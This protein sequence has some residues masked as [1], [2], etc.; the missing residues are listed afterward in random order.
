MNIRKQLDDL[1]GKPSL[2]NLAKDTQ[3]LAIIFNSQKG[4]NEII[5][6]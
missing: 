1:K 3:E 4:S 6:E 2:Q 5:L